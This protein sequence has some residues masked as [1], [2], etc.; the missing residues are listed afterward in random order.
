MRVHFV[1]VQILKE[2]EFIYI[3]KVKGILIE[4]CYKQYKN[5]LPE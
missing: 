4:T 5:K 3:I 1:H 2:N